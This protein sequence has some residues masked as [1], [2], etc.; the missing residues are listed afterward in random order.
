ELT[1]SLQS[2]VDTCLHGSVTPRSSFAR[3]LNSCWVMIP[4]L[5]MKG[6]RREGGRGNPGND[7]PA[8]RWW[9]GALLL[10]QREVPSALPCIRPDLVASPPGC[11][12]YLAGALE[13]ADLSSPRYRDRYL[14]ATIPETPG[15]PTPL[16][17]ASAPR[18]FPGS[19]ALPRKGGS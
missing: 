18:T 13:A 14:E 6:R 15:S 4:S 16:P 5:R 12:E 8:G 10:R 17:M 2:R 11:W 1:Q 7:G 9:W 19:A 3:S